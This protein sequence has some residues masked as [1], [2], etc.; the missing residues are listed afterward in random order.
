MSRLS[1]TDRVRRK[2]ATPAK[3]VIHVLSDST[4]NLPRHMMM[5]LLT[6]FPANSVSLRYEAFI[7]T[8]ERLDAVLEGITG[9]S[10]V[11]CHAIISPALKRRIAA[12]CRAAKYPCYDLTGGIL[13]FLQRATGIEPCSNV[14]A[15]HP[16]DD[17]YRQR[18]GA[19]EYTLN[20]DDGLGIET[21]R[22]A[23]IVLAGVSRTS[24]TPTSILLAQQGY[25]TANVSLAMGVDVP[26]SLLALPKNKIIGLVISPAQLALIRARRQAA[27]N[28]TQTSY[29]QPD[30]VA[31][32]V[33]WSRAL[34]V[35]QGWPILDVTDQAVEETAGRVIEL[36][37]LTTAAISDSAC[38]LPKE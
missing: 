8:G 36:L 26:A 23:D 37:G 27:W 17:A 12:H 5:A 24:K 33:A 9:K 30:N 6:Q 21:L 3:P 38:D 25:R 34:F 29:G 2:K 32:E 14:K 15:L 31:K 19:M 4:A 13:K 7:R 35:R 20:H 10:N 28:M 16:I 1:T 18:I 11:I 22:D